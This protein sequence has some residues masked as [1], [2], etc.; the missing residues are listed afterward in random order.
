MKNIRVLFASFIAVWFIYSIFVIPNNTNNKIENS[1]KKS[2]LN[3]DYY[4]LNDSL[5][6]IIHQLGNIPDSTYNID[7]YGYRNTYFYDNLPITFTLRISF[8]H[9]NVIPVNSFINLITIEKLDILTSHFIKTHF[10]NENKYKIKYIIYFEKKRYYWS[11]N[12]EH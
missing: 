1:F 12:D 2:A 3:I 10:N 11:I 7:I 6:N 5:R 9:S 4:S 8:I